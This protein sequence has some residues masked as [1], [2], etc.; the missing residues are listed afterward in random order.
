MSFWRR[1][2][3]GFGPS[4]RRFSDGDRSTSKRLAGMARL[5]CGLRMNVKLAV[6][7]LVCAESIVFAAGDNFA[8][9]RAFITRTMSAESVPSF[10]VAVVQDRRIVW[11]E[12]FGATPETPFALASVTKALTGTALEMLVARGQVDLDRPVNAYLG[13][14][15]VHSTFW[16]PD[17]A[18]VR[19]IASHTAGL[20]TYARD[21]GPNDHGCSMDETIRHY[22]VLV[23]PPGRD[24]DYSNLDYGILGAVIARASGRSYATFLRDEVFGPLG[25]TSCALDTDSRATTPGASSVR[26]N[27]HDLALFAQSISETRIA[28]LMSS[29]VSSGPGQHYAMGWWIQDDYYGYRSIFGSGGTMTA[30]AT[31][32]LVPSEHVAVV[33]L[34]S[35]GTSLPDRVADAILATLVPGIRERQASAL[36]STTQARSRPA[37]SSALAGTWKGVIATHNGNR[38]LELSIDRDGQVRTSVDGSPPAPFVRGYAGPARVFGLMAADLRVADAPPP[39]YD[40]QLGVELQQGRLV[41]FVTTQARP[42]TPGP[43][44]SF[45]VELRKA[46]Q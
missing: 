42:G 26:C 13:R 45:W 21:C 15:K 38:L 22:A 10:A 37:P 34:A 27:V 39:P 19:R 18:T 3:S 24:F 40:L 31:L 29:A 8:D 33:A 14:A 35:K 12:G 2:V 17:E 32:R 4:S 7:S 11:E 28:T 6:L 16:N 23:R 9:V 5:T 41:G 30:S 25:M 20:T 1:S 46:R 43:A 36:A 44:L